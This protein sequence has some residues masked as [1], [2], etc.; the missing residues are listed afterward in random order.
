MGS[1][2]YVDFTARMGGSHE[3]LK[4]GGIINA[5]YYTANNKRFLINVYT[6]CKMIVKGLP[7]DHT[8]INASYFHVL[9]RLKVT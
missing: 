5:I 3:T 4:L 9:D 7:G 8:Y 6:E 1:I 2:L